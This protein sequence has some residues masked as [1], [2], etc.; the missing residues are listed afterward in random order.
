MHKYQHWLTASVFILF[1]RMVSVV[2]GVR[3]S[4][5]SSSNAGRG[6]DY[7]GHTDKLQHDCT[8]THTQTHRSTHTLTHTHWSTHTDAHT[9]T[10]THTERTQKVHWQKHSVSL[11]LSHRGSHV[12]CMC[13]KQCV[14]WNWQKIS[15]QRRGSESGERGQP[16][17]L[18]LHHHCHYRLINSSMCPW[19]QTMSRSVLSLSVSS[20]PLPFTR[21]PLCRSRTQTWW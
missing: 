18:P 17:D 19:S 11:S 20:S 8:L 21:Q 16:D 5:S 2:C 1:L 10:H 6:R 15:R 13:S 4:R 9:L 14:H 12:R 3:L 7:R